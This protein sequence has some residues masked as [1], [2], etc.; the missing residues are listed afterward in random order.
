V[1]QLNATTYAIS[2]RGFNV[3][4]NASLS[5]KLLVLG[6]RAQHLYPAVRWRLLDM[7]GVPPEDIER[8]EVI[9]GPGATLW[10]ANAVNGVNQ[11]HHP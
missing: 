11:H 9:S 7:Q 10:G 1:A 4:D 5:N 2:A 3:G 8:I 6:R